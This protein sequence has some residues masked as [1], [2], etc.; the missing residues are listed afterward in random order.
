MS[1]ALTGVSCED[2]ANSK[3]FEMKTCLQL[4]V[5]G[6]HLEVYTLL[7]YFSFIIKKQG[8]TM[9]CVKLTKLYFSRFTVNFS[10]FDMILL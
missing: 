2:L 7:C 9:A 10:Y 4:A 5:E 3:N 8:F 6:G 1:A